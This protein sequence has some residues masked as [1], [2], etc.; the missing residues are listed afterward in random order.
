MRLSIFS[1]KPFHR[2]DAENAEKTFKNLSALCVSAVKPPFDYRFVL[3]SLLTIWLLTACQSAPAPTATPTPLPPTVPPTI[4]HTPTITATPLPPCPNLDCIVVTPPAASPT[5]L[6]FDLPTP[7]AEPLSAWRPP[8]F[9]VPLALS[10]YDHFYFA[11]P[12]AADEVNWPLANYRYGGVFFANV[13]HTGVDIP[14]NAGTPVL[15][16]GDG[17]V[18]WAGWGLFTGDPN[19]T[20]DPYGMAVALR[21][22][23]GY[24]SQPLY[25]VYA[26][27]RAV[28]VAVGQTLQVG[29]TL[30]EV[31]ATGMTT[32]P[33]LHF[34]V[35]V[36]E[37]LYGST[38]NPE[39]WL[40]PPQGWGVLAGRVTEKDRRLSNSLPV[41]VRSL[42][43]NRE[44]RVNTYGPEAVHPDAYYNENMVI[45]D[46][47]AG[48]YSVKIVVDGK[49]YK[50]EV[51]IFPG[52][53]SYFSYR[54][55]YGFS[56]T[57]PPPAPPLFTPP[58]AP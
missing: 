41:F 12:I 25:T 15:A 54:H 49:A 23:F 53:V 18:V 50:T 14:A 44:W 21:H 28:D 42:T 16:T 27:M 3:I 34:E 29:Q 35:R 40:A 4:T 39:L 31:G 22:N 38:H 20:S 43:T 52:Q 26:H 1:T 19:N 48:R 32:G 5:P 33:H 6:R 30:G 11:R 9:P 47:P 8:Q 2:R 36:G 24:Q 7:G 58:P 57:P 45:S 10:P 46:L 37:N 51:E 56:L 17:I 13:T 55:T